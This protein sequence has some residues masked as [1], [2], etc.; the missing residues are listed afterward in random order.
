MKTTLTKGDYAY[1]ESQPNNIATVITPNIL[2]DV[3]LVDFGTPT[4][5]VERN[6]KNKFLIPS[7]YSQEQLDNIRDAAPELLEFV[8]NIRNI[9]KLTN[10]GRSDGF[11]YKELLKEAQD[12]IS[13]AEPKERG[14]TIK[15]AT[16]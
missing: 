5:P 7:K 12:L 15:K 14:V 6:I 4:E 16:E 2:P 10:Q 9:S 13:K 11:D 1:C 3:T 8:K